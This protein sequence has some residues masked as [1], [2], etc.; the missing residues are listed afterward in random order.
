MMRSHLGGATAGTFLLCFVALTQTPVHCYEPTLPDFLKAASEDAREEY[1][2]LFKRQDELTKNQ[3][4]ELLKEWSRKQ[5][6]QVEVLMFIPQIQNLEVR[7]Y[8]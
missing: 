6:P 7:Q 1:Y 8:I 5:G 2:S 4:N 3:L